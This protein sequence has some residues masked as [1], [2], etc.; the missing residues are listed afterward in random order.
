[1][2][3]FS[4]F[5]ISNGILASSAG[6]TIGFATATFVKSLVADV[7]MPLIFV[8]VMKLS[9]K[10][11]GFVGNFL[12]AKELRFTNFVSEL[13]TWTLIVLTAFMVIQAI[14]KEFV[15]PNSA[16]NTIGKN[17]LVP[18]VG[19]K[20]QLYIPG[21]GDLDTSSIFGSSKGK[22]EPYEVSMDS[23]APVVKEEMELMG[24]D[25]GDMQFAAY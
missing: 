5:I 16:P 14:H 15:A 22:K 1:M 12:S 21:Y 18:T 19:V 20:E 6:I 4:D 3:S 23:S 24:A 8:I 11:G 2:S 25:D 10:T 13:I 7:I 9:K 17:P